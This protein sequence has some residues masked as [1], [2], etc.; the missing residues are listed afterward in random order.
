[1]DDGYV[2]VRLGA[3]RDLIDLTRIATDVLGEREPG[4]ALAREM[5][6]AAAQVE[7]DLSE[8]AFA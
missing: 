1:M 4:S 7:A 3:L 8:P 5:R 6:G 2:I